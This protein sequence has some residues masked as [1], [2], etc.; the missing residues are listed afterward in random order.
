MLPVLLRFTDYVYPFG[1]F[2]LV[3]QTLFL[4]KVEEINEVIGSSKLKK[5]RQYNIQMKSK[6]SK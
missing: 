4:K 5:D 2:K 3:L 6:S 1:I